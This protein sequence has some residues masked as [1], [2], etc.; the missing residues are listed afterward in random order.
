MVNGIVFEIREF[1]LFDGPGTRTTVFLKGCPLRC[2][3]CHNPEGLSPDPEL[4]FNPNQCVHCGQCQTVCPH[5]DS[6]LGCGAC[7]KVCPQG[8]RRICGK[9]WSSENLA[10]ELLKNAEIYQSMGGGITFSGGEPSMQTPFVAEVCERLGEQKIHRAVETC[11][12]TS[13]ENYRR[14]LDSVDFIFQDLKHPDP[15]E[16][17]KYT[18]QSNEPILRNLKL[19]ESANKPYIIRIPLIPGVNTSKEVLDRF[20][21]LITKTDHLDRVELLAYHTTAGAKYHLVGKKYDSSFLG[22][23]MNP[24]SLEAFEKKGLPVR[25]L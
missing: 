13:E 11:G 10:R 25:F 22:S 3:W 15:M 23:D 17:R 5:P 1:S 2:R 16:H 21:D 6:C 24:P 20:A 18:G 7:A 14:I 9:R 19:L 8:C 4:L 12:F